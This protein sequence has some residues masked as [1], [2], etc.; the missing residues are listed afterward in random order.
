MERIDLRP[1]QSLHPQVFL[2]INTCW[3]RQRKSQC[4]PGT[5]GCDFGCVD[6]HTGSRGD[7]DPQTPHGC[8]I[9]DLALLNHF[10]WPIGDNP[11]PIRVCWLPA[12]NWPA[13]HTSPSLAPMTVM[14]PKQFPPLPNCCHGPITLLTGTGICTTGC[15]TFGASQLC[16]SCHPCRSLCG[17]SSFFHG[18]TEGQMAAKPKSQQCSLIYICS[19]VLY[20]VKITLLPW[21]AK[22]RP[23]D[24]RVTRLQSAQLSPRLQ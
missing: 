3:A 15:S 13:P 4:S 11:H 22:Y 21:N 14:L 5:R 16:S 7:G 18:K 6:P 12:E 17:K 1:P 24:S 10:C 8:T 19:R 9:F 2:T 23:C 20:D